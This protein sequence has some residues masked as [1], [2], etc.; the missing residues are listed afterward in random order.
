[1]TKLEHDAYDALSRAK[2]TGSVVALVNAARILARAKEQA[3]Y[4]VYKEKCLVLADSLFNSIGA[5]LT[6][7]KHGAADGRGNFIDNLDVPLNDSPW[8]TDQFS[9]LASIKNENETL[10]LINALMHRTDAGTGGI[11]TN[12]GTPS[13]KP[14]VL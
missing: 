5:Q 4:D 9:K 10:E 6:I 14:Y 11:Y 13:S 3:P 1:E 12:F 8:L 2:Q 7:K